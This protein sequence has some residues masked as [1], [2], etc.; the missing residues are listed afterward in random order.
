MRYDYAFRPLTKIQPYCAK[1]SFL[2]LGS[3]C[4]IRENKNIKL[5]DI[6]LIHSWEYYQE[7]KTKI[8]IIRVNPCYFKMLIQPIPR[9]YA[10]MLSKNSIL[11]IILKQKIVLNRHFPLI[12]YFKFQYQEKFFRIPR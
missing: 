12:K 11:K 4:N 7:T 1:R 6:V 3:V 9:Y 8:I 2:C 5:R 10:L